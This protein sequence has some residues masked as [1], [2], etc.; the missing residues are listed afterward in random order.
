MVE[1]SYDYVATEP[2][3]GWNTFRHETVRS[4]YNE[5]LKRMEWHVK[6][7]DYWW[8]F[9]AMEADRFDVQFVGLYHWP[10]AS[11]VF[12]NRLLRC[13]R[14]GLSTIDSIDIIGGGARITTGANNGDDMEVDIGDGAAVSYVFNLS[15]QPWVHNH[16][17]FPLAGDVDNVAFRAALFADTDNYVGLRYD[18]GGNLPE[19]VANA[20]MVFVTRS[21]GVETLTQLSTPVVGTWYE[22]WAWKRLTECAICVNEGTLVRHTTNIPTGNLTYSLFLETEENAAKHVDTLHWLIVQDHI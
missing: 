13:A 6:F 4:I 11:V 22:Y 18:P 9:D 2:K 12:A 5:A 10:A 14:N 3:I 20:M 8:V 1:P 15:E 19:G 7:G 21:A 16:F 17:R